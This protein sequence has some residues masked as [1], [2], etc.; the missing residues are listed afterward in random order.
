MQNLIQDVRYAWRTLA[1]TPLFTVIA[2]LTLA[3]GIGANTSIFTLINSVLLRPLPYPH[4]EQLYQITRQFP[5]GGADSL[6]VAKF[7]FWRDNNRIFQAVGACDVLGAGANLITG[8]GPERVSSIRVSSSFF[9]VLGRAPAL[10]RTFTDGEDRPG[11]PALVVLSYGL[12]QRVF[13]GDPTIIGRSISLSGE[14]HTVVGIMPAGFQSNPSADV[15]MPLRAGFDPQD[16]ANLLLVVAR[17]KPDA[18]AKQAQA[19]MERVLVQMRRDYPDLVDTDERVRVTSYQD[20]LVGDARRPLLVLLGAVGLVLLIACANVAN[21]LLAR[22]VSR[23]K[24]LAL[25]TALG[26]GRW[27]ILRQLLTESLVLSGA[28]GLLGLLLAQLSLKGLLALAP[29]NLPRAAEVGMNLPVLA[30]TLLIAVATGLL[31]GVVPAVE[32]LRLNVNEAL[33]EGAG[34]IT[35]TSH[36]GRIRG[37]LVVTEVALAAVLLI[38]ATLLIRTFA[39]LR[40][41]NTGFDPR[42]VLTLKLSLAGQKYSTSSSTWSF[43][44]QVVQRLEA[45]PG[46]ESAAYVMSLPLE[47]GPD[48]PFEVEGQ[49]LNSQEGAQ[50]RSLTPNYFQV[51]R[52]PFRLGRDFGQTDH[53]DSTGVV[54]VNEAFAHTFF[55]NRNALGQRIVIGR[56]MGREF[57]D[58]PR[59][60]VGVVG[61][62]KDLRLNAPVEPTMF[63]PLAQVPDS[64]TRLGN[65]LLPA[66]C[67]VRTKANP[68]GLSSI[69]RREILAVDNLQPIAGIRSME[70]VLSASIAVQQF[71]MLLLTVFAGLALTLALIGIYGIMSFSVSQRTPE[72]GIRIALGAQRRDVVGLVIRQ[73]MILVGI[74]I[75]IGLCAAFGLTHLLSTLLYGVTSKDPIT[76]MAIPLVLAAVAFLACFLPAQRALRI[77]PLGALRSE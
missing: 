36:R 61:N 37:L 4:P 69:V 66:N 14:N 56:T 44:R 55:P 39:N 52:I 24:E 76:F 15:W 45:I 9:R 42:N 11:S 19:E 50:W 35:G 25:R 28:G 49:A 3:L 32:T 22:A 18:T 53:E 30:F 59:E 75:G 46:V 41:V 74:G 29:A 40:S 54:I 21:L 38:G 34:R 63:V 16:K 71:N 13:G 10:G 64:M 67:V 1:K 60:I 58:R 17:A 72:I 68:L 65:K 77:D 6:S 20:Q 12:W 23:S 33:R 7:V 5:F 73:G 51:M 31:F 26:A 8:S 47:P 70:Q 27:A 2:V 43:F 62:V 57:E 48:L